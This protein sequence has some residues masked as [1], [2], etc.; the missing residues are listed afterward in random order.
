MGLQVL[1]RLCSPSPQQSASKAFSSQGKLS[2][3]RTMEKGRKRH[4]APRVPQSRVLRVWYKMR[5]TSQLGHPEASKTHIGGTSPSHQ[6]GQFMEVNQCKRSTLQP[7]EVLFELCQIPVH[8]S[9]SPGTQTLPNVDQLEKKLL[10]VSQ[11]GT[12]SKFLIQ[13]KH[14]PLLKPQ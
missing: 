6:A 7:V 3:A 13:S 2:C 12:C 9:V 5:F 1:L 10:Q 4:P 11:E 14:N 8:I